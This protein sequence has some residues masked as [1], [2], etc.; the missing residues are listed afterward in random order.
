MGFV[1]MGVRCGG[2]SRGIDCEHAYSASAGTVYLI[3]KYEDHLFNLII[4]IR[5]LDLV[6]NL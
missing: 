5:M 1:G 4:I 3:K 6:D 2:L